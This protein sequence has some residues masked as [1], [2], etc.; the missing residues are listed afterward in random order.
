[1]PLSVKA[2]AKINLNLKI[3]GKRADGY[4]LLETVMQSV[5]LCDSLTFEKTDSGIT[6]NCDNPLLQNSDNLVYTASNAFFKTAK[7]QGGVTINLQKN[8]PVKSGLGGG[9]ADAAAT[10]L[11]LNYLY[12]NPLKTAEIKEIAATLG[13]DVPFFTEGGTVLC[14]GIGEKTTPL[15]YIGNYYCL[16]V[17]CGE[18]SSTKSMYEQVDKQIE[19]GNI[20]RISTDNLLCKN[21]YN[22]FSDAL[23]Y[24]DTVEDVIS[25]LNNFGAIASGLS[26]SGP[27]VYGLFKN[28]TEVS[29]ANRFLSV[30]F[31]TYVCKTTSQSVIISE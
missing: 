4:H 1:M 10:L 28:E 15:A 16:L 8:I 3:V 29:A 12:G 30:E 5:D 9:S 18:K 26:G 2:N 22:S 13:A 19:S 6:L 25:S 14:E 31:S 7:V 24:K 23:D 17:T 27:T 20:G 11:A 21:A